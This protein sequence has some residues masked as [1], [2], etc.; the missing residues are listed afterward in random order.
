[1]KCAECKGACCESILALASDARMF[2]DDRRR[3]LELHATRAG[4]RLEFECRCTALT[5]AGRCSIY[6]TRPMMCVTYEAG[7]AACLE[8]VRRRR[9]PEDYARIRDASDPERIHP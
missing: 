6:S 2:S 3:W 7:G 1:M 9:T 5:A 8:T 4:D